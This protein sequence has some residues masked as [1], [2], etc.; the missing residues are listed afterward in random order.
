M[1]TIGLIGGISWE[2]TALYYQLMNRKVK[3]LM[4]GHHSCQC[5]LFSVEFN[6]VLQL[7]HQDNWDQIGEQ[8]VEAAKRLERGGA[9]LLVVCSNTMHKVAGQIEKGISLPL[10][11]IADVTAA[12]IKKQGLSRVGLLGTKFTMEQDFLKDRLRQMHGIETLVPG[13]TERETVHRII[14]EELANGTIREGSRHAY[15]EIIGQ[16]AAQ[17]AEG[18]ILGCTEIG[19]LISQEHTLTI[20]FD[21]ARI[22]AEKAVELALT[23]ETVGY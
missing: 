2:S 8:M 19:L 22:H 21:T 5:L 15:L 16:L 7:Q 6:E 14:Y 12:E 18:I 11:H 3:E 4:G 9:D 1:K 20:L 23:D 10:V 17:G 13:K